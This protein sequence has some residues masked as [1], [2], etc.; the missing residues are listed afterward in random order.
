MTNTPLLSLFS[1]II[2][3]HSSLFN[4]V[5][6]SAQCLSHQQSLLLQLK[7]SF[8]FDATESTILV[9]WNQSSDCC[10]WAG[11]NCEEG[12]VTGL[13]LR[14]E[15]ISIGLDENSTLWSLIFL[16]TLDLSLNLDLPL[17][18]SR[19]GNL[20]NMSYLNLS[21]S[22]SGQ[23][24][25]EI[26]R[27][28][29]LRILD[30]SGLLYE[31]SNLRILNLRMLVQNLTELEELYL[32]FVNKSATG[33][34]WGQAL[35]SSLHNLRVLSLYKCG[36][37][38][39]I[40]PSLAKLQHLSVIRFDNNKLSSPVPRFFGNFSNLTSLQLHSCDLRG[41]FPK[42]IFQKISLSKS[43]PCAKHFGPFRQPNL[44]G[45]TKL[46]MECWNYRSSESFTNINSDLKSFDFSFNQLHGKILILPPIIYNVDLSSNS[47]TSSIPSDIGNNL[48]SAFYFS[49]SNNSLTGIIPQ[50]ICKAGYLKVLDLSSN[51]LTATIPTCM[52]A[53]SY[54]TAVKLGRNNLSGP[55][56]DA[57]PV[58]CNFKTL[59][60]NGNLLT[61][62]IPKSLANC[63]ALEYLDL[64]ANIYE[65]VSRR[66]YED[67]VS[68]MNKGLEME[69]LKIANGFTS[70]DLSSNNFHGKMPKELR[71]LKAL[72]VLNLSNNFL[73]EPI[74][75]SFGNMQQLESLDLSRNQLKGEIPTSISNLNFLSV[76]ILSYNHLYGRIPTGRQI[77]TFPA[78]GFKGNQGLCGPPLPNCP[79]D[80]VATDTL[81]E[82]PKGNSQI[83][84]NLISAE[85]GFLVGFGTVV[86]PL[87]F[88]KKWRKW[89][90][91]GVEDIAFSI[92]PLKLLRKWS[93]E[94]LAHSPNSS[95][96]T[97]HL[98][99]LSTLG[100]LT[101]A[102]QD[103]NRNSRKSWV[104]SVG[105]CYIRLRSASSDT[106]QLSSYWA[107]LSLLVPL[108]SHKSIMVIRRNHV[109]G[110][111]TYRSYVSIAK[112][113][114]R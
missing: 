14:N 110:G 73:S 75:S 29:K 85:I 114:G 71:Q 46:D 61:H 49:L 66:K 42:E 26:S 40:H 92:L 105:A 20:T 25:K 68:V 43:S 96:S 28:K 74:P 6:V 84:W 53:L 77:Q 69:L 70:I 102:C 10:S 4:H 1:L 48:C 37:G 90:F 63:R 108:R 27:L 76:L 64:D 39:P 50:S 52:F 80:H 100:A 21:S 88:W 65:T 44:W 113:L 79:G 8:I 15:S 11:I 24:P 86:G 45:D 3:I 89:Y 103:L 31:S 59:N 12:H 22:F 109:V 78:D 104:M 82:T 107:C 95:P 58:D 72:H 111:I 23:I 36:L 93:L 41:T 19:I 32:D 17:I 94:Q 34:E 13:N 87:V 56:P 18:P 57:F 60:L 51:N 101:G 30:L 38:G 62:R 83:E 33:N 99:R 97:H 81:P 7:D 9:K 106:G 55:I 112:G 2:S 54:I 35:S 91:G 16:K 98:A 5:V 47:F 67:A